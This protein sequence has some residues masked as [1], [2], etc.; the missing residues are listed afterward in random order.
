MDPPPLVHPLIKS[1]HESIVSDFHLASRP[2]EELRHRVEQIALITV[3][4]ALAHVVADLTDDDDKDMEDILDDPAKTPPQK[5]L[6]L[7]RFVVTKCPAFSEVLAAE[8]ASFKDFVFKEFEKAHSR[9]FKSADDAAEALGRLIEEFEK[10][11]SNP[12]KSAD[13]ESEAVGQLIEEATSGVENAGIDTPALSVAAAGF[14]LLFDPAR[15]QRSP[16]ERQERLVKQVAIL[17]GKAALLAW[18]GL[19]IF[20]IVETLHTLGIIGPMPELFRKPI[21]QWYENHSWKVQFLILVGLI[22]AG[23]AVILASWRLLRAVGLS[24]RLTSAFEMRVSDDELV[25]HYIVPGLQGIF[26]NGFPAD[27]LHSSTKIVYRSIY[28][29]SPGANREDSKVLESLLKA[30]NERSTVAFL[31]SKVRDYDGVMRREADAYCAEVKTMM[32]LIG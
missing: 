27:R 23:A 6:D 26:P 18:V 9:P 14:D 15:F 31:K 12:F 10:A 30:G 22:P 5:S 7:I 28:L 1:L 24:P 11:H 2:P 19:L 25:S 20:T 16:R 13:D 29:A 3:N 17:I 8:F 21:P 4:N 32:D